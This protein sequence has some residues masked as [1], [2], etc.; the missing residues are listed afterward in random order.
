MGSV[1]DVRHRMQEA[2]WLRAEEFVRRV[3][4]RW[5]QLAMEAERDAFLGCTWHERTPARRGWR[6]GY[7]DRRLQTRYGLLR[8]RVPR[9]RGT[10]RPWRTLLFDLYQRRTRDVEAAVEAWVAAGCSTRAVEDL[11][12]QTFGQMLSPATVSGIL[13]KLDAELAAWRARDL[14]RS[15]RVL[16]L[17]AKHGKLRKEPP[18]GR[19]RGRKQK[20]VL[21]P[22]WGLTHEGREELVDF[23][24]FPGPERYE[25]WEP[26]LTRLWE[27]GVRPWNRWD[28]PLEL[29]ATDGHPGLEAAVETVYPTTPSQRCRF[30]KVRN[31]ADYLR[32]R[33]H[34]KGVLAS[35][36]RVWEGV[37]TRAEAL[38]RLAGWAETWRDEEPEAVAHLC[39]GFEKTLTYLKLGP[40]LRKRGATTNPVERFILEIEK[41][42][43][44]V[45]VWEDAASWER[46]VWVLWKRLK[47]R[48]YRPT[49]RRTEITHTS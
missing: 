46:H 17:D 35:A 36:S 5:C 28:E 42:T 9:V 37:Q 43:G 22:A 12:V 25:V 38:R 15:Y 3:M 26:F 2:L 30:H 27:R 31:V 33:G 34:R 11:M 44:H 40:G 10:D 13:A 45:P 39:E 29:I 8:L 24:A 47:R 4:Q 14:E 7:Q 18:E 20:G 19:K 48:S 21:L 1:S 16:W 32:D 6:N 49:R 23:Q 41:A